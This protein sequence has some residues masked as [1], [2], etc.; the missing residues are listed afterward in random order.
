M[1]M[2]A[3]MNLNQLKTIAEVKTFLTGAQ[4]VVFEVLGSKDDTYQW[5]DDTLRRLHYATLKRADKGVVIKLL[6]RISG[7][8]RQQLTRLIQQFMERGVI[9]RKQVTVCGFT[10]RFS[11]ADVRLLASVDALHQLSGPATKR[12][13]ARAVEVFEQ[14]EFTKLATISVSHL[15]NLRKRKTYQHTRRV[16]TKTRATNINIGERRKPFPQGRPGFIRIDSVHQGDLDGR[17][18]VYLINAVDEVTQW[19]SLAAVEAISAHHLTPVLRLMLERFPFVI[20]N[21]HADN[22][23]EYINH[24]VADML[25]QLHIELTKSRARHS[26]DNALAESKNASTVRKLFGHSH[27]PQHFASAINQVLDRQVIPYLNFHRPCFFAE[28]IIDAKGKIKKRYPYKNLMTPFEKL[29]ALPQGET[30]L[31]PDTNFEILRHTALAISDN[32]AAE[33]MRKALQQ[34]F[35]QVY[36]RS[37]LG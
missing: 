10:R 12:I 32:Q 30:Y 29:S 9:Q 4:P 6:R 22:G 2:K 8:S 23:G 35:K 25:N 5:I 28:E 11:D 3:I 37:Q 34:L 7:Y 27:I 17:K 20:I 19:Q 14:T 15:Y 33:A 18:G 24:Q 13:L 31:K 1:G 26:N 21:F 16:H 36:G